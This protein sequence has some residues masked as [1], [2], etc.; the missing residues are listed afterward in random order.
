MV[1][2]D[3]VYSSHIAQP[4]R[5]KLDIENVFSVAVCVRLRAY[6][7]AHGE[8]V[9]VRVYEYGQHTKSLCNMCAVFLIP[10]Q[11]AMA[12]ERQDGRAKKDAVKTPKTTTPHDGSASPEEGQPSS[13]LPPER[14]IDDDVTDQPDDA[15]VPDDPSTL[16]IGESPEKT[17]TD[18]LSKQRAVERETFRQLIK[19]NVTIER[20]KKQLSESV[21]DLLTKLELVN[22]DIETERQNNATL[23]KELTEMKAEMKAVLLAAK[24]AKARAKSASEDDKD[25]SELEHQKTKYERKLEYLQGRLK[26]LADDEEEKDKT[27]SELR[28]QIEQKDRLI[29]ELEKHVDPTEVEE[30]RNQAEAAVVAKTERPLTNAVVQI[31][32]SAVCVVQ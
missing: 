32:Q 5:S 24:K 18:A 15:A 6:V 9:S 19:D 11:S 7:C 4:Q 26:K 16:D 29:A 2:I 22:I 8:G 31:P 27:L 17:L 20:E 1:F 30:V 25:V 12:K 3:N 23:N 14:D 13:P 21:Q 28:S 10:V